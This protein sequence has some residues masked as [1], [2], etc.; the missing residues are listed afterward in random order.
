MNLRLCLVVILV[1]LLVCGA[2]A[3]DSASEPARASQ[4]TQQGLLIY[5]VSPTYPPSARQARVQGVVTLHASI[6]KNGTVQELTVIG[7]HP[8]LVQAA[9]DAVKQWRYQ[10]YLVDGKPVVVQ[11]TINV[12]FELRDSTSQAE[13]D[14]KAEAVAKTSDPSSNSSPTGVPQPV[15]GL[16]NDPNS[17]V[18]RVGGPVS[19][20]KLIYDPNPEYSEEARNARYQGTV[21]LRL[22]VDGKGLP[23]NI[24]VQRALGMGLDAEAVKAVKQWRFEPSMKDGQPVAVMINVEVS[25]RLYGKISP[26]PYSAAQPP[27]FPGVNLAQYPLVVRVSSHSYSGPGNT[28]SSDYKAD[29]SQADKHQRV[30]ISCMVAEPACLSLEEGTY[31]ARWTESNK[32]IEILGIGES[33]R[34]KWEKTEYTVSVEHQ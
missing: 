18:Y 6:G 19:P 10:P 31:P 27:S 1:A 3:Q 16:A 26:H 17:P 13:P 29:I 11:T 12:N 4:E 5:R 2:V 20:P 28:Q 22:I 9:I 32:E 21:V 15:Q 14:G 24:R 33:E 34:G 8:M 23:Q 7:G 25:F 30:T